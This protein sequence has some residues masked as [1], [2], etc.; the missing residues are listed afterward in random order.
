MVGLRLDRRA[1]GP[2]LPSGQG[3][4][5]QDLHHWR[6]EQ[7]RPAAGPNAVL[8]SANEDD[9]AIESDERE[10]IVVR[11]HV[12][13]WLHLCDWRFEQP[14]LRALLVGRGS[15]VLH[16]RTGQAHRELFGDGGDESDSIDRRRGSGQQAAAESDRLL[17]PGMQP[18]EQ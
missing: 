2:R 5:Q 14:Q 13:V 3:G 7:V 6:R 16:C 9:Q 12:F 1:A 15:M 10:T 4:Q 17:R 18:V 11:L 8:Q